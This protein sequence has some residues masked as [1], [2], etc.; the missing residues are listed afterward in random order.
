[1]HREHIVRTLRYSEQ[2]CLEETNEAKESQECHRQRVKPT[3][4]KKTGLDM[5]SQRKPAKE[6]MNQKE[7]QDN[8]S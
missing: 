6:Q 1:M 5:P 4:T 2:T 7:R 8:Y 3:E